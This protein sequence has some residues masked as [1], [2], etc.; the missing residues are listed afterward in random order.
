MNLK[1]V[2]FA[3]AIVATSACKEADKVFDAS[4]TFEADEIMVAAEASGKILD[5]KVAEGDNLTANQVIGAIDG[6]NI[7]LQKEQ[8]AASINALDQKTNDAAPQIA[9]FQQQIETAK[10]NVSVLRQQL[11]VQQREQK[12]IASLVKADAATPK[13]LDDINGAI[14]VLNKQIDA[15]GAQIPVLERQISAQKAAVD[16]QNRSI[17]SEK[18]PL[19]KRIAQLNDQVAKTQIANPINGTVTAKYAN[20]GEITMLGKTL[21]KIAD[22]NTMTLRA[23]TTGDLLPKIKLNQ[24]VKVLVDAGDGKQK[25]MQGV[26]TYISPKAEFT[27]KTIQTK[28]ERANLVYAMK[29]KVKN[30]GYLKIGMYGEV[31]F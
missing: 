29:I 28:S 24:T 1:Y 31:A 30:D 6:A 23:Y 12:R 21:Y 4:G 27:P 17:L 3:T 10:S 18:S 5:L 13:Q 9:V 14:D 22:L 8:I 11:S 19:Q 7:G 16:I 15:A 20:A 26:I 2:L 25:E